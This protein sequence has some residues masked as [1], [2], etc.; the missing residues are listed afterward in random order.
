MYGLPGKVQ[1]AKY[2]LKL[3]LGNSA[4]TCECDHHV[5]AHSWLSQSLNDWVSEWVTHA[6]IQSLT[7]SVTESVTQVTQVK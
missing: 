3:V 7:V 1:L 5:M 4:G 6:F 2:L